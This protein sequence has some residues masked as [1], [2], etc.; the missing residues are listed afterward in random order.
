ML[1]FLIVVLALSVSIALL[2]YLV[3]EIDVIERAE[4][5]VLNDLQV[6]RMV[7]ANEIERI[8]QALRL[9]S[10]N[11]DN[12]AL[13]ERLSLHYL[14]YIEKAD[15]GTLRSEIARAAVDKGHA[16]GGTRI[17]PA[18]ESAAIASTFPGLRRIDMAVLLELFEEVFH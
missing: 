17:V 4:H 10:P 12:E 15:F 9:V 13:R 5:K 11:G 16:L 3:I 7:Y 6:A 14:R 18:A 1:S 8:G 2:G